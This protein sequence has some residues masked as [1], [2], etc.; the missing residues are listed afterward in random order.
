MLQHYF[1][2]TCMKFSAYNG[3]TKQTTTTTTKILERCT[4]RKK[5]E[6]KKDLGKSGDLRIED[7]K[8]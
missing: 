1:Y 5:W 3:T 2:N 7:R 8:T 4:W 6:E